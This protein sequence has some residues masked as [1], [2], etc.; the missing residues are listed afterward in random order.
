MT[1]PLQKL[2]SKDHPITIG[3]KQARIVVRAGNR[4]IADTIRAFSLKEAAYPAVLYIPRADIDL[5]QLERTDLA[6]HCPYKG[7]ASYFSIPEAG[8]RAVNIAWSYEEPY[9]AV[10]QIAG[11]VAFYPDRAVSIEEWEVGSAQ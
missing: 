3:P 11:H 5:S 1:S 10:A 7:D 9:D 2:P 6:T 8:D 4:V